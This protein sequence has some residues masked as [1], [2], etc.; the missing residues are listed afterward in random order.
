MS[1]RILNTIQNIEYY[2]GLGK[3]NIRIHREPQKTTIAKVILRFNIILYYRAIV[4]KT[5]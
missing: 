4:I 3:T 5:S 1:Y 2:T